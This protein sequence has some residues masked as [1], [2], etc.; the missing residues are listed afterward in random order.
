[1]SEETDEDD[2]SIAEHALEHLTGVQRE[3]WD[4]G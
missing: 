2:K 4:D 1:M 3:E